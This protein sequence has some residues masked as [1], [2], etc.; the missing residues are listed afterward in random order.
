M[1]FA[2]LLGRRLLLAIV[3]ALCLG[4]TEASAADSVPSLADV[5]GDGLRDRITLDR[6][7][8]SLVRVRLSTTGRTS[9]IRSARPLSSLLA[10]DIDGDRR[11]E[12]IAADVQGALHVWTRKPRTRGFRAI[13][14]RSSASGYVGRPSRRALD[15]APSSDEPSSPTPSFSSAVLSPAV[16]AVGPLD[17]SSAAGPITHTQPHSL[18]GLAPRAPRPPPRRSA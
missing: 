13:H 10:R 6:R 14:A 17:R 5:D 4:T 8:P 1:S 16:T 12:L 7:D 11:A 3:A 2:R 9:V 18:T 15:D